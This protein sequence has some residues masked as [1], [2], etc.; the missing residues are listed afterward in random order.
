[1]SPRS[2]SARPRNMS[3][4]ASKSARPR[5]PEYPK[6]R[7]EVMMRVQTGLIAFGAAL[8]AVPS[9]WCGEVAAPETPA[10]QSAPAKSYDDLF[11]EILQNLPEKNRAKVDS[12]RVVA[13]EG[14]AA[15]AA[16][17]DKPLPEQAQEEKRQKALEKLSPDVK[18]RV[19]KAIK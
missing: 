3:P 11:G 13:K 18:K 9:A 2:G 17:E 1:M 15:P 10:A 16:L 4:S 6:G 5:I 19:E 12:A 7:S 8:L 14:P